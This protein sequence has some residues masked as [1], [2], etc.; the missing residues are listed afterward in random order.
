MNMRAFLKTLL[1]LAVCRALI[2]V[3]GVLSSC[4][5]T[6]N[7][8][9]SDSPLSENQ[10]VELGQ[11]S[12]IAYQQEGSS[13]AI[14]KLGQYLD[15][16]NR[17]EKSESTNLLVF[18]KAV[19]SLDSMLAHARLA[20]VYSVTGQ[21]NLAGQHITEALVRASNQKLD[22]VTNEASLWEFLARVDK[23]GKQ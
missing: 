2:F 9:G 13:I 21:T 1:R 18:S 10:I 11:Q 23:A 19:I 20:K 5:K 17:L 12:F 14:Q 3:A 4:N 22:N 15:G 8:I 7:P 16:L 6:N